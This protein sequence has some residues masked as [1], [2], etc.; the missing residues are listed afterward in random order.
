MSAT[1]DS[2]FVQIA[3][4]R[5]RECQWTVKDLFEKASNPERITVGICWQFDPERDQ[6]CFQHK[7]RPNQVRC[8]DV[9]IQD[10]KGV[11]WARRQTQTLWDG[12]EYTLVIDSHMRF[13]PDWDTQI[14][15]QLAECTSDKPLISCNPAAYTPPDK[16]E[17]NP[18][19][20][21]RRAHPFSKV[22]EM[23]CRGEILE[24]APPHPLNGAFIAAGLMFSR[25]QVI[26]EVP[27]DP[28]LYFN[29]EEI[30]YAA[31][32]YTH[33]WDIFSARKMLFYHWYF[34]QKTSEQPLHW[35][36]HEAWEKFQNQGLQRFNHL[37]GYQTTTDSEI[38]KE[39]DRYG[40]GTKRNL[41]AFKDYCGVD[42]KNKTV[43]EKGLYCLFIKDREKY[44]PRI[45]IPE[46]DGAKELAT[47]NLQTDRKAATPQKYPPLPA[48]N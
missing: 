5:D 4:Y 41:K 17:P 36:D 3:S 44:L 37:T 21:I 20:T 25:S 19:P 23:R 33:G 6:A 11:C 43:S 30:S 34:N 16:L 8:I 46:L 29:Q 7:T 47:P 35:R 14:I 1:K 42:F 15:K 9:H 24:K 28:Y 27:Y 45:Y 32:L 12:E 22:G 26:E 10:S 39:L 31:R 2:I 40:L 18:Y 48:S 13:A 38:I